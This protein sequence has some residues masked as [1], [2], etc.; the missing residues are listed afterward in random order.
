MTFNDDR[1]KM[2]YRKKETR[3]FHFDQVLDFSIYY[4]H[5]VLDFLDQRIV[6]GFFHTDENFFLHVI[7]FIRKRHSTM[8]VDIIESD[9][10]IEI[11]NLMKIKSAK[12]AS[13]S[14]DSRYSYA[15]T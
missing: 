3:R 13:Q 2:I 11:E 4:F 7:K 15:Y 6:F 10:M 1:M 5:Q 9:V 8:I 14:S 12:H